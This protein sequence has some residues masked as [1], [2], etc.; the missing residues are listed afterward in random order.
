MFILKIFFQE[1]L[2]LSLL[3]KQQFDGDILLQYFDTNDKINN[4]NVLIGLH[5]RKISVIF[6]TSMFDTNVNDV[7]KFYIF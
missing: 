7:L 3:T 1:Y 4:V 6:F 5:T 2:K